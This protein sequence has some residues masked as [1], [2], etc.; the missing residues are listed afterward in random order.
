MLDTFLPNTVVIAAV[1]V[2]LPWST[3]PIVPTLTCG[4][5]RSNLPFAISQS[6][7]KSSASV[8]VLGFRG[9]ADS[10]ATGSAR[11]APEDQL[12]VYL[13][14]AV[15][16]AL[17]FAAERLL[18]QKSRELF[19]ANEKLAIHA[20][21]LSDQIVEQR[22]VVKSALT[23]AELLKG[24]NSRV[25]GDLD[26]AHSA[27]VM[28]ERRLWDSINTIPDGFAVFD[29]NSC[30]V[31]ANAAYLA[32]FRGTDIALGA[33]YG[34]ILRTAARSGLIELGGEGADD[35]CARMLDRWQA[36]VIEPVVVPFRGGVWVR[37]IDRRARDGDMV[38]LAL[39]IT[40]EMRIWAAIEA[41]PDGFVLFDREE[42]LLAFNHRYRDMFPDSAEAMV[43]GASPI[44]LPRSPEN[45][46]TRLTT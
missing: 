5:V 46:P 43:P 14:R 34:D 11:Q 28:A 15:M 26:R 18:E 7:E 8:S 38:S 45:A 41:I 20:R 22:Q 13:P 35:W 32:A 12:N 6:P 29:A 42:R 9:L 4:L 30:L 36:E 3:W 37:L 21:S 17:V 24:Q 19:T 31:A 16:I 25:K 44:S 39:N 2:V 33:T 27:A 10:H 23:E 1:S 40:E